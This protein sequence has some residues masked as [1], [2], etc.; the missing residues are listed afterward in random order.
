MSNIECGYHVYNDGEFVQPFGENTI[1]DYINVTKRKMRTF[2][3]NN[4]IDLCE[5]SSKYKKFI[6][7]RSQETACLFTYPTQRDSME[8][9]TGKNVMYDV[10]RKGPNVLRNIPIPHINT[11]TKNDVRT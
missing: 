2:E 8:Y 1:T 7:P 10:R 11:L 3:E 9:I 6:Q 4:S 5:F